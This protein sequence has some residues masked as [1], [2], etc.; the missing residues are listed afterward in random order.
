MAKLLSKII[1]AQHLKVR[2][3]KSNMEKKNDGTGFVPLAL[4]GFYLCHG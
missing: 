2:S 1:I 4:L 3:L